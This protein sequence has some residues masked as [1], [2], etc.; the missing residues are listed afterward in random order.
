MRK[1][2]VTM[3]A[4]LI[5]ASVVGGSYA[6]FAG[7]LVP[8]AQA[9]WHD[10]PKLDEAFHSLRDAKDYLEAAP[11]DF[12]GHKAAAIEA[13]RIAMHRVA[14]CAEEEG[15]PGLDAAP[16]PFESHPKLHEAREHL[17]AAREYLHEANHDFHGH[18]EDAIKAIDTA[19]HEIDRCLER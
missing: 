3:A 14:L 8:A 16:A 10:H 12:H 4:A 2:K 7:P 17:R 6:F 9:R 1:V 13:I 15:T 19:L 18:R 5:A 11:E